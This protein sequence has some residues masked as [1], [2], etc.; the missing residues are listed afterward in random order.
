MLL[1]S[2]AMNA[3]F[4]S[5]AK[6]VKSQLKWLIFYGMTRLTEHLKEKL[7]LQEI[8]LGEYRTSSKALL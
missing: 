5:T 1:Q 7:H 4:L 8:E 6:K 3:H 2:M